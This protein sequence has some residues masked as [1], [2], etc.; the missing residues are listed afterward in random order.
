MDIDDPIQVESHR[1]DSSLPPFARD[2]NPF[3]SLEPN[4]GASI[5]D[6]VTGIASRTSSTSHPRGIGE[7][8]IEVKDGT[9]T[10]ARS[11]LNT[12]DAIE[13]A[14]GHGSGIR[15]AVMLDDDD[16][17]DTPNARM[18]EVEGHGNRGGSV[19]FGAS[20]PTV[21]DVRDDTFDIEEEMIRAA[22]E[23]SRQDA[24]M[25]IQQYDPLV[26]ENFMM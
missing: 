6:N 12:A 15:G 4:F 22:I 18:T 25:P 1:P 3:S 26:C 8:P 7:I 21:I 2:V 10:S 17:D 24:A 9:G 13:T 14:H 11:G 19:Q 5:I 23:A 16:D 20:A